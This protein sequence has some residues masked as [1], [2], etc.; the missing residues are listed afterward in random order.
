MLASL[1]AALHCSALHRPCL[2]PHTGRRCLQTALR[3]RLHCQAK[4]MLHGSAQNR[5]VSPCFSCKSEILVCRYTSSSHFLPT[6]AGISRPLFTQTDQ[7]RRFYIECCVAI[8]S[9]GESSSGVRPRVD[10]YKAC[11]C[12]ISVT[13]TNA[14]APCP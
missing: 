1:T 5:C 2:L 14:G 9:T 12:N 7:I 10:F 4:L 8:I 11:F 6:F 13:V 3:V